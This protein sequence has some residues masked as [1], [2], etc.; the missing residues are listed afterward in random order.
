MDGRSDGSFSDLALFPT[1]KG[2]EGGHQTVQAHVELFASHQVRI[3]DVPL[4]HVGLHLDVVGFPAMLALPFTNLFQ[5]SDEENTFS[6]RLT[7]RLHNP[8]LVR[9][10]LE[11]L[12]EQRVVPG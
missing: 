2:G 12:H 1:C 4:H 5:F 8:C 11:L 9:T 7:D 10:L 3:G 6:L